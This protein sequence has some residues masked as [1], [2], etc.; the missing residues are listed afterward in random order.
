METWKKVF[1][2]RPF[3]I[4]GVQSVGNAKK[5]VDI[6][7]GGTAVNSHVGRQVDG[8]V[9]SLN[10]LDIVKGKLPVILSKDI[11]FFC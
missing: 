11:D 7:R 2:G 5:A 1:G 8:T 3:I 4:K 6:S 9:A 10:A